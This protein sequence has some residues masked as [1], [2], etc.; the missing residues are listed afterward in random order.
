ME[1]A[2][3]G[4]NWIFRPWFYSSKEGEKATPENINQQY[5]QLKL[6]NKKPSWIAETTPATSL[7]LGGIILGLIGSMVGFSN[8]S[9]GW[10]WSGGILALASAVLGGIGKFVYGVELKG[11]ETEDKNKAKPDPAAPAKTPPAS[12]PPA[13]PQGSPQ[14]S[15][16]LSDVQAE[17]A[18]EDL[19]R[20]MTPALL[21]ALEKD[22]DENVR[23]Q[24]AS[25]LDEIAENA[26]E[27]LKRQM[28]PALLNALEKDQ[29]ENVRWLAAS[30][31][32]EIAE[33]APED[34][35]LQIAAALEK[36]KKEKDS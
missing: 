23:W 36:A 22:Q 31:L 27:D 14:S 26:P 30:A 9:S 25:A 6:E 16:R 35:K 32:D 7:G 17:N 2:P 13:E 18:P 34:L 1:S 5:N 33:N 3:V 29:D 21:N 10:K 4:M 28:T 12:T 8:D 20:Q 19:K 11:G 24:A 15:D